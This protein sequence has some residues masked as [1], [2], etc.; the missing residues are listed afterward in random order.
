MDLVFLF[1][2]TPIITSYVLVVSSRMQIL[3]SRFRHDYELVSSA[4]WIRE[5]STIEPVLQYVQDTC[6]RCFRIEE[7]LKIVGMHVSE[8]DFA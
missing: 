5:C 4:F 6:L 2:P 3:R 8:S 7:L 1:F